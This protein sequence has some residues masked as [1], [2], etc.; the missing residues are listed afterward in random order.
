M[1][2]MYNLPINFS[3]DFQNPYYILILLPI[4]LLFTCIPPPL[5]PKNKDEVLQSTLEY[6][7]TSDEIT[8]YESSLKDQTKQLAQS[9]SN[10]MEITEGLKYW[11]KELGSMSLDEIINRL[12]NET[13]SKKNDLEQVLPK[14]MAEQAEHL[15]LVNRVAYES[16]DLEELKEQLNVLQKEVNELIMN[17]QMKSK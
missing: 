4:V 1:L 5:P 11:R 9:S 15:E 16:V 10:L 8:K 12:E 14:K 6:R 13:A 3:I 2:M 7:K 17:K